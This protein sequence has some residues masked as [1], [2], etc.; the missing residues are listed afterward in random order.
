MAFMKIDGAELLFFI[1]YLKERI[2]HDSSLNS[3]EIE[4]IDSVKYFQ[5]RDLR[6]K[7]YHEIVIGYLKYAGNNGYVV[8][9]N[10]IYS[11]IFIFK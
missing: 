6:T 7:L 1:V 3:T 4:S 5:P 2:Y 10:I 9:F 8:R 11:C